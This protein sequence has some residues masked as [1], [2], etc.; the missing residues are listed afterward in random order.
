MKISC[1][2]IRD[3]LPLYAE[4]MVSAGSKKMVEEHLQ[5]CP[6]CVKALNEIREPVVSIREKT[7]SGLKHF[8]KRMIQKLVLGLM[9]VLFFSITVVVWCCGLML[10][11]N[12]LPEEDAWI[13]ISETEQSVV[14]ELEGKIAQGFELTRER[15]PATGL[16]IYYIS[17]GQSLADALFGSDDDETLTLEWPIRETQAIWYY[18][19]GE[20]T[21]LYGQGESVA[22]RS[23]AD[24][25]LWPL[26]GLGALLAVIA[27][28]LQSKLLGYSTLFTFT[29]VLADF[30]VTGCDWFVY[31][32]A[33]SVP[34][35]LPLF[36]AMG[37]LLTC[38]IVFGWEL[39]KDQT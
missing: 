39:L 22:P 17:G 26:L 32:G 38:C 13:H 3:L 31:D 27:L 12:G 37:L 29:T 30:A 1:D 10:R 15:D 20:L 24:P 14:M 34:F 19:Y 25:I 6:S 35:L 21:C 7:G 28:I 33:E 2:V 18:H 5:E 9:A 16:N 8:R 36:M 11:A 23:A 4:E